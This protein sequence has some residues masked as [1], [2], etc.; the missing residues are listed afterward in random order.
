MCRGKVNRP[1]VICPCADGRLERKR[2][3]KYINI[4]V[5]AIEGGWGWSGLGM[6]RMTS[7]RDATLAIS[8]SFSSAVS[9]VA[10]AWAS[11]C[12][13]CIYG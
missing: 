3:R 6:V 2:K 11:V 7:R 9:R 1:A 13:W 5:R 4:I 8:F 12:G 10:F